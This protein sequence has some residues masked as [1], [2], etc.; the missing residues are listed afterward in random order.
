[1]RVLRSLLFVLVLGAVPLHAAEKVETPAELKKQIEAVN[2]ESAALDAENAE[3]RKK[4]SELE[5]KTRE[6]APQV[7]TTE[8]P[9]ADAAAPAKPARKRIVLPPE[10]KPEPSLLDSLLADPMMLGAAGGAIILLLVLVIVLRR[11][12]R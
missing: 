2:R 3:L 10:P 1:M 8:T 12:R 4:I 6:L 11:R 5:Q 7:M 9:P